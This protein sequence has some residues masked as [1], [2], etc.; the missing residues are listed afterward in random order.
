MVSCVV[1]EGFLNMFPIRLSRSFHLCPG[2]PQQLETGQEFLVLTLDFFG[3]F[4]HYCVT[5]L[6]RNR[7]DIIEWYFLSFSDILRIVLIK[8]GVFL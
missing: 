4:V 6:C 3:E 1:A 5:F 8:L 2:G 7:F